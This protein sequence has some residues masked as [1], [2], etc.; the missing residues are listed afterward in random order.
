MLAKDAA[1][2]DLLGSLLGLEQPRT[3]KMRHI[4]PS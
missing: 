2:I 1:V 3:I 4:H